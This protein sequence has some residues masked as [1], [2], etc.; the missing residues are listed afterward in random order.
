LLEGHSIPPNYFELGEN[1]LVLSIQL[2]ILRQSGYA[3]QGHNVAVSRFSKRLSN[4]I[5]ISCLVLLGLNLWGKSSKQNDCQNLSHVS[6]Q[7]AV[8]QFPLLR[9]VR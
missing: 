6:L 2:F 7:L 1:I 5:P 3:L 8:E 9:F 4:A